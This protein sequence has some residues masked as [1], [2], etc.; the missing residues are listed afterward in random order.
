MITGNVTF[1]D[2]FIAHG[3]YRNFSGTVKDTNKSGARKFTIFLPPEVGEMLQE[4]GW[5]A[6]YKESTRP[7]YDGQWQ[8]DVFVS[9]KCYPPVIKLKSYDGQETLLTEESVGI[10]DSTDI[11]T[12]DLEIRPYN[13]DVN[14]K[15]GTKAMVQELTVTARKPRRVLDASMHQKNDD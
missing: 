10:L 7:E 5:N 1:K 15:T 12:A 8:M 2:V 11:E 4:E 14:G 6:K 3:G 9:Y 13:W